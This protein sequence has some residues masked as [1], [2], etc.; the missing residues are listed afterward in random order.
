MSAFV[1]NTN[2]ETIYLYPFQTRSLGCMWKNH[3]ILFLRVLAGLR[4]PMKEKTR[5]NDYIRDFL[6][7]DICRQ[8]V[9]IP[10]KPK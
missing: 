2:K 8:R 10:K 5:K 1:Q 9:D 3:C 4:T 6:T 7:V